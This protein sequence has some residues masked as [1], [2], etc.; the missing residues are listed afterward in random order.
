MLADFFI[1]L[2]DV[3]HFSVPTIKGYRSALALVLKPSGVDVSASSEISALMRSFSLEMGPRDVNKLPKWDLSLVLSSLLK[4]PYEPLGSVDNKFLTFKV[5]FLLA[6][7]SAKR[8][9]ELQALSSDVRHKEDW[10]VISF[11]FAD[12]FLAKTELPSTARSSV[13]SFLVPA[14]SQ[15]VGPEEDRLLCPVR[16]VK[17]YLRRTKHARKKE[18][19]RLFLPIIGNQ[20]SVSKN[21]ISGW[22]KAVIRTAYQADCADMQTLFKVSAHEVRALATSVQFSRNQSLEAVMEAASWRC[23]ST[24]SS[25]YLRDLAMVS[26]ELYSLG[27]LVAAQGIVSHPRPSV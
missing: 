25:F 18:G 6:L 4:K 24:F 10:S 19:S 7:A 21:T 1:Y 3:K 13:R 16:A 11:D 26:K 22:L 9:S 17:I 20:M 12:D 15:L 27:P 5:V 8:V 14:L 2:R 23:P